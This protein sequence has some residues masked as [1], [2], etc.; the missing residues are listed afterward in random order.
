MFCP[1]KSAYNRAIM[2]REGCCSMEVI[3]NAGY[4]TFKAG[5]DQELFRESDEFGQEFG[6]MATKGGSRRITR[7]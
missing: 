5:I 4:S 3:D 7:P 1:S 2:L 6:W